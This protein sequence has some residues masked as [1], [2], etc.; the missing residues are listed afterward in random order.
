MRGV[1]GGGEHGKNRM[2]ASEISL[3]ASLEILIVFLLFY[4]HVSCPELQKLLRWG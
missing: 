2:A 4:N 1:G 3:A